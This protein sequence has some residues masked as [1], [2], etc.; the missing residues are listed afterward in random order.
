MAAQTVAGQRVGHPGGR[1]S[2]H[3]VPSWSERSLC[4][5]FVLA[6]SAATP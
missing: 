6:K 4:S 5:L 2:L 1:Y 3:S